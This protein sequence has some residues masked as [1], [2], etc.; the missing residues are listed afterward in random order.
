M[1]PGLRSD[2][3][4]YFLNNRFYSP[5]FYPLK[6]N[7]VSVVMKGFDYSLTRIPPHLLSL[8]VS[9]LKSGLPACCH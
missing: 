3:D 4:F 1:R 7:C 6:Y 5:F 2:L 8:A 9:K